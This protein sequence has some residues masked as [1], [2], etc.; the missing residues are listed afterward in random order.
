MA[1]VPIFIVTL[2]LRSKNEASVG[3]GFP[4]GRQ[5]WVEGVRVLFQTEADVSYAK[6]YNLMTYS[7]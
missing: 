2:G 7:L 4:K 5:D 1:L 6:S 3:C